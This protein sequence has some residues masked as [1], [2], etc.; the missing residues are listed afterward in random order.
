MLHACGQIDIVQQK[1]NEI[2]Q[3][4]NEQSVAKRRIMKT[5]IIRHQKIISFSQNIEN[6]FSIIAL[7]HFVSN[8]LV[9]VCLGFLIVVVSTLQYRNKSFFKYIRYIS[10]FL[11]N[12]CPGRN[13]SVSKI[14]VILRSNLLRCFYILFCRRI[15]QHKSQYAIC[16]I[17]CTIM[18][19]DYV[20]VYLLCYRAE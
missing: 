8:T 13:N 15:S 11:V 7:M 19:I 6:L 5:L 16:A 9:I 17:K 4:N 1:L 18:K 14:R 3:K 12:R 20:T 10:E 2:T